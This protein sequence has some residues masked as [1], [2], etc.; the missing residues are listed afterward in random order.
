MDMAPWRRWLVAASHAVRV[1][2]NVVRWLRH[3]LRGVRWRAL[4]VE[5]W[6][7]LS[8]GFGAPAG[9]PVND[10][11]RRGGSAPPRRRGDKSV[12]R[13]C[14]DAPLRQLAIRETIYELNRRPE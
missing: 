10:R 8:S 6:K 1:V 7:T 12:T 9:V 11:A 5:S 3:T 4:T 14:H 2:A 13:G